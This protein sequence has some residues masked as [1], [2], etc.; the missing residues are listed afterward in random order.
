MEEQKT[1]TKRKAVLFVALMVIV[2]ISCVVFWNKI[3][4]V[5][6]TTTKNSVSIWDAETA[7]FKE[8]ASYDEMEKELDNKRKIQLD[9]Y[10]KSIRQ[11]VVE[12]VQNISVPSYDDENKLT[13]LQQGE[14]DVRGPKTGDFPEGIF[15]W[16]ASLE[17]NVRSFVV[18]DFNND[19]LDD[20]AHVVGY[21]GGG[22]GYFYNLAIFVN[23]K[24]KLKYLTQENLGDRIFIKSMKYNSGLFTVDMI[25][26]GKGDD[27]KG[28]C[29]ANVPATLKY[30]LENNRLI[31]K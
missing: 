19:G 24:G 1:I 11:T 6:N 15:L 17:K 7:S 23:D 29:C 4:N 5:T 3:S 12:Q 16:S 10:N 27:F 28:Y 20:V 30:K 14:I 2:S 9:E 31:E 13:Q 21:T 22:S 26:Q 8:Y 25:T 18:D